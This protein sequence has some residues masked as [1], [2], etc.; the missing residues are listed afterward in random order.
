[1]HFRPMVNVAGREWAG[2]ALVFASREEAEANA[3]N[4]M[5]R[6]LLVTDY[7]VDEIDAPVNYK[8]IDG[9]LVRIE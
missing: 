1:M 4:L 8:W 7:R 5:G 3:R 6:W 2:N 9:G